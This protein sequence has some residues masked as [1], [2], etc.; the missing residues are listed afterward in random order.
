MENIND[1]LKNLVTKVSSDEFYENRGLANEVPF[2]IFDYNPKDEISVRH[3]VKNIFLQSFKEED[4]LNPVEIDL[5]ELLLESMRN[6]NILEKSFALEEKKGTQFLYEK[7]KKSF[8][9]EIII[10][11]IEQKSRG[12]NLVVITGIGKVYPIVRTHT[13]LNNLQNIFD[14][15]KVLLFFPGEYTNIDLRL[16]GFKDNNY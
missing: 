6:D 4:R 10:N 14:H 15:T 1:R 8:N 11:Y 5:F 16:F 13:V 7:L 12:K 3:F 9:S 2:Y